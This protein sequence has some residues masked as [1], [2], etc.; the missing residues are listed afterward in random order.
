MCVQVPVFLTHTLD[1]GFLSRMDWIEIQRVLILLYIHVD[2]D[3]P[4]LPLWAGRRCSD[5][6]WFKLCSSRTRLHNAKAWASHAQQPTCWV[7]CCSKPPSWWESEGQQSAHILYL[8]QNWAWR[9]GERAR[10][11]ESWKLKTYRSKERAG[12]RT[13]GT[14]GKVERKR[15][16][17]WRKKHTRGNPQ[18]ATDRRYN[19]TIVAETTRNRK[20]PFGW[21][22]S[23]CPNRETCVRRELRVIVDKKQQHQTGHRTQ[24]LGYVFTY[25]CYRP[26]QS[27]YCLNFECVSK[28]WDAGLRWVLSPRS[29]TAPHSKIL[30]WT[31]CLPPPSPWL[32]SQAPPPLSPAGRSPDLGACRTSHLC[33]WTPDSGWMAAESALRSPGWWGRQ[34][35]KEEE[36]E[37]D[38]KLRWRWT[39][40][41]SCAV[42]IRTQSLEQTN[43]L[44]WPATHVMKMYPH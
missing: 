6:A 26:R 14:T 33:S 3:G 35:V 5:S 27:V 1:P 41:F 9:E 29:C 42:E 7:V 30:L 21:K 31:P 22:G 17:R 39:V 18:A 15:G 32:V 12:Q 19:S 36:E 20:G 11:K 2:A 28:F 37:E 13:R 8:N 10:E 25:Q 43:L 4:T 16:D 24:C 40:S 23:V 44:N 38:G 34:K